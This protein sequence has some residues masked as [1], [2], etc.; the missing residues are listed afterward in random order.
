MI[1]SATDVVVT[2]GLTK[3]FRSQAGTIP[4]LSVVSVNIQAG[5]FVAIQGASGSG[6][7]TLLS[8]LG[9]LD[10]PDEGS[11]FLGGVDVSKLSFDQ[12]CAVRA[13]NIGLIFQA[14]NLVGN[15][16]LVENICLAARYARVLGRTEA[17][18]AAN[19]LLEKLGLGGRGKSYPGELSGGQQQRVAIARALVNRPAL[20]LADEPTGNL[21]SVTAGEIMDI[22]E[23]LH[24][25]GS[26]VVLVTHEPSFAQRAQR[27]ITLADGRVA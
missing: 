4:A 9:L 14:F 13:N 6:K 18:A 16:D 1:D 5:E 7:S 23:G 15:L 27:M 8:L 12:R 2:H 19:A 25:D 22:L 21:D 20:I 11:Y 17:R 10:R 24:R 26:T 3:R